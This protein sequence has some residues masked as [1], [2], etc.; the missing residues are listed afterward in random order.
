M[1]KLTPDQLASR[2][3]FDWRIAQSMQGPVTSIHAFPD[4]LSLS[5]R[6]KEITDAAQA[7]KATHYL[8]EFYIRSLVGEDQFHDRFDVSIDLLAGGNYP[9]SE[10][11]CFVVS[12]PIPWSPHF[13]EGAPICLGEL[14]TDLSGH[15]TLGH[16]VIHTCKLLNWDEFARSPGY[17]GWRP[18][19]V[20]YWK[21]K[22]KKQP[23][24]P[25][26]QYPVLPAELTHGVQVSAGSLFQP[27]AAFALNSGDEAAPISLFR[28]TG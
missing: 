1:A 16:L 6:R 21:K 18:D 9:Y 2:L 13:L 26:L 8:V 4:A 12:R 27:C 10:P 24:T 17:V 15:G 22:L 28:P 14:W 23:I 5:K 3:A 11:V 25:G 7:P 20:S 19:A